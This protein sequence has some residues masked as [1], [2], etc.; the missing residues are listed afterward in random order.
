M[1]GLPAEYLSFSPSSSRESAR[2]RVCIQLHPMHSGEKSNTQSMPPRKTKPKF[3]SPHNT[4]CFESVWIS[5]LWH[6]DVLIFEKTAIWF[7]F[8]P[9]GQRAADLVGNGGFSLSGIG[10]RDVVTG[11]TESWDRDRGMESELCINVYFRTQEQY[12]DCSPQVCF[13]NQI[14][15]ISLSH[16]I[17]SN[18]HFGKKVP[19]TERKVRI[20]GCP[21]AVRADEEKE[22][23]HRRRKK[24]ELQVALP[25]CGRLVWQ[26]FNL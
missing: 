2:I 4:E 8:C 3:F 24:P 9:T 16:L 20:I 19:V 13:I 22:W 21:P 17:W 6:N 7:M 5:I 25:H 10:S 12:V 14:N 23:I 11:S 1:R 26:C 18:L 15:I